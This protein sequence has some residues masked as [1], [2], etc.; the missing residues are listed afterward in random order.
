MSKTMS[1]FYNAGTFKPKQKVA[2][3][4]IYNLIAMALG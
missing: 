3:G 2:S 4:V 1:K